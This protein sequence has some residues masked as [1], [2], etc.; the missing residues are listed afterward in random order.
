MK[1]MICTGIVVILCLV[2]IIPS[3]AS[4]ATR[5]DGNM[6]CTK[7][8]S[9]CVQ[10]ID[11]GPLSARR[12]TCPRSSCGVTDD[13]IQYYLEYNYECTNCSYSKTYKTE[14]YY[15]CSGCGYHFNP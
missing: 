8:G 11:G 2:M 1:K 13:F 15:E 3:F 4:A 6:Y 7:C 14:R 5:M 9:V 12:L 10:N